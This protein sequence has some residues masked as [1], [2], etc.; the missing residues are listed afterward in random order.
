MEGTEMNKN[1]CR[2]WQEMERDEKKYKGWKGVG[3]DGILRNQKGWG[4]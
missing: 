3:R 1:G 4:W 2:G